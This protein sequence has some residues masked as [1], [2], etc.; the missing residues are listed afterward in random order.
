VAHS[1]WLRSLPCGHLFHHRCVPTAAVHTTYPSI[2]LLASFRASQV[3]GPV[4][5][6]RCHGSWLNQCGCR[7][8]LAGICGWLMSHDLCPLCRSP[9]SL[10]IDEDGGRRRMVA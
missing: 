2:N 6:R 4:P 9:T 7:A 10:G 3:F 8:R 5:G 1:R